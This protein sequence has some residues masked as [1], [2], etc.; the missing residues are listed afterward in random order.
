MFVGKDFL[1]VKVRFC[2]GKMGLELLIG[3][4]TQVFLTQ[5]LLSNNAAGSTLQQL[6][7]RASSRGCQLLPSDQQKQYQVF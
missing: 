7:Q 4:N 1:Q 6:R 2:E 3:C 5:H